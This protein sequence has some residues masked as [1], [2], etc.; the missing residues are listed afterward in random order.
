[1]QALQLP[2][3]HNSWLPQQW[4]PGTLDHGAARYQ[5]CPALTYPGAEVTSVCGINERGDVVGGCT[6]IDGTPYSFLLARGK[7]TFIVY[8]GAKHTRPWGVNDRGQVVGFYDAAGVTHGFIATPV[9]N[10]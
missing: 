4:V 6:C 3:T 10:D 1:M 8:P 9:K 7:F 2:P 5:R